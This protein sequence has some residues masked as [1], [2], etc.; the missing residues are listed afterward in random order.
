MSTPARMTRANFNP[1]GAIRSTSWSFLPLNP[2]ISAALASSPFD[3]LSRS[4]AAWVSF[5]PSPANTTATPSAGALLGGKGQG[6]L[7]AHGQTP[8]GPSPSGLEQLTGESRGRQNRHRRTH[9]C[10]F[11]TA[12]GNVSDLGKCLRAAKAS[13]SKTPKFRHVRLMGIVFGSSGL[14]FPNKQA[15]AC[16]LGT[17]WGTSRNGHDAIRPLHVQAGGERFLR[18]PAYAYVS[19]LAGYGVERAQLNHIARSGLPALS[20]R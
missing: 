6:G 13:H 11:A 8:S 1:C 20:C 10:S 4:W 19:R 2:V 14:A 12:A 9:W 16:R 17:K 15:E 5:G 3:F 18:H 7:I